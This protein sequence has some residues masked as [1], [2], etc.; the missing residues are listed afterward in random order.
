[1]SFSNLNKIY[2]RIFSFFWTEYSYC[3]SCCGCT[4][5]LCEKWKL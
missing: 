4:D 5:K 1:M 2:V 3:M